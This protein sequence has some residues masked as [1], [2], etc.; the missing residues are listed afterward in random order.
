MVTSIELNTLSED[1][2]AALASVNVP[3]QPGELLQFCHA[4]I[5]RLLRINPYLE[6]KNWTELGGH[7]FHFCGI[8]SSQEQAFDFDL[9]LAVEKTANGLR[10]N[11]ENGLKQ[12]TE[13]TIEPSESGTRLTIREN[14]NAISEQELEKC[15]GEI[16]RSL[17]TWAGDLQ[18]FFIMWQQ[19]QWLAPWRWYMNNVWKK[20]KPTGRRIT[21]MFWWITVV[22]IALIALGAVI[23][24][25]EYT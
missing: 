2:N 5:E 9:H 13:F 25:L 7:R 24:V 19:W 6:F 21:Y 1:D 23:Y 3:W 22:E 20:L 17:T 15:Q 8:N 12:S 4:D 11:Y 18:K 14:Y 10:F 16:D